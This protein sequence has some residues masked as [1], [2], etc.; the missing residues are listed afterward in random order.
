[1][2][3]LI[4]MIFF[5]LIFLAYRGI[6]TLDEVIRIKFNYSFFTKKSFGERYILYQFIFLVILPKNIN[7]LY[8]LKTFSKGRNF[9]SIYIQW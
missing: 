8:L 9:V 2:T 7:N 6:K 4:I 5:V 3:V 1:M